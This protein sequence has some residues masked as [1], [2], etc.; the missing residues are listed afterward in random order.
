MLTREELTFKQHEAWVNS[1]EYREARAKF[2]MYA[3]EGEEF[4][5]SSWFRDARLA[6]KT[7]LMEK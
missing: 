1:E 2:M 5:Q 4:E 3:K 7:R 6:Y